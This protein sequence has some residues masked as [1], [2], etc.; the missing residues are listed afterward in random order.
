[1]SAP[2]DREQLRRDLSDAL[3]AIQRAGDVTGLAA[4]LQTIEEPPYAFHGR[5]ILKA[6]APTPRQYSALIWNLVQ[7][8]DKLERGVS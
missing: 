6:L 1:M 2:L 5:L 4:T 8:L 3:S 7:V